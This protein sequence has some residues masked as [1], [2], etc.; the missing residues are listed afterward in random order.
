MMRSMKVAILATTIFTLSGC[1]EEE[2]DVDQG[3][4]SIELNDGG[5]ASNPSDMSFILPNRIS[6]DSFDNHF[7]FEVSAGDQIHIISSLE[8]P[9]DGTDSMRCQMG[10]ASTWMRVDGTGYCIIHYRKTFS[11][12]SAHT[13]QFAPPT[14]NSGYFDAALVS[15]FQVFNPTVS[16]TGRPDDPRSITVGGGNNLVS[17][18]SFYNHFIYEA[19]AGETLQ[20]QT[21]PDYSHSGYSVSCQS[22]SGSF[23]SHASYGIMVGDDTV[24]NCG[25]SRSYEF[26]ASGQYRV[27]IRFLNGGGYF[28]ANVL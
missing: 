16:A 27:N 12:D 26:A 6:S 28:R 15:G 8:Y 1:L 24:F 21:Y 13:F 10:G 5:T 19:Q 20:I 4:V 7:N 17:Q 25:T 14:G 22:V 18:N 2:K 11:S 3:G 23:Y 9:I